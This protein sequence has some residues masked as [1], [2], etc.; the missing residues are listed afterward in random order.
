M[1]SVKL[2]ARVLSY[3]AVSAGSVAAYHTW[4]TTTAPTVTMTVSTPHSRRPLTLKA[5]DDIRVIMDGIQY[6]DMSVQ[7]YILNTMLA[8][9]MGP[10][11]EPHQQPL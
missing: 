10:S 8:P 4:N 1:L 3:V 11:T 9:E 2:F 7:E 6:E 5:F